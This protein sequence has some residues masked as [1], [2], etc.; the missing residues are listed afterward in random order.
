MEILSLRPLL[1]IEAKAIWASEVERRFSPK[2]PLDATK[3]MRVRHHAIARL[4]A[5]G[6]K[7]AAIAA[8]IG[9][10][11]ASI[12]S[13]ER[14]PVFQALLLEY[15]NE[16]DKAAVETTARL[17]ILRNLTIDELTER[18][19]THGSDLKPGELVE[20]LKTTAD[21]TGLGP[22]QKV[23]T[24]LNGHISIADLRAIKGTPEI[25]DV[26]HSGESFTGGEITPAAIRWEGPADEGAEVGPSVRAEGG[27]GTL[28]DDLVADVLTTLDAIP[29]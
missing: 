22:T 27:E 13:L 2:V 8:M 19:V 21:R 20:I 3:K 6:H 23:E 18:V 15:M 17:S 29:R 1:P 28:S 5:V 7:P 16:L 24:S 10:S 11:P 12:A 25:I 14:T 9:I 26:S 4:M